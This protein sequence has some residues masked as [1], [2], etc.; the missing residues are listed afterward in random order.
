M[1]TVTIWNDA[2]HLYVEYNLDQT[3]YESSFGTVHLWVGN[4]LDLLPMAPGNSN[5]QRNGWFPF[6]AS[7]G[8]RIVNERAMPAEVSTSSTPPNHTN[9]L[10]KIPLSSL[11]IAD[12][13][14]MCGMRLYV[15]PHAEVSYWDG[16]Q[17]AGGDTAYGGDNG[18]DGKRWWYYGTHNWCCS[19]DDPPPPGGGV[20]CGTA[21]MFGNWVW[22]TDKKSQT[23]RSLELTRNR[24]GWA[25]Q[26]T[27]PGTYTGALY[28]GAGLNNIRKADAVG[29]VTITWDGGT[30]VKVTYSLSGGY[31]M[32]EAHVYVSGTR[33]TTLAPGQFGNTAYYAGGSA[34]DVILVEDVQASVD[35]IWVIAHAVVCAQS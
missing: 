28:R 35:G 25:Y 21:F 20:G 17:S 22:T 34:G 16:E 8:E 19:P 27:Q 10:F 6:Q 23:M 1:G 33:P 2:T 15:V 4:N 5:A 26:M 31:V 18:G 11:S 30:T 9:Y 12:T 7:G 3:K 13:S 29:S 24:W 32:E 14:Q